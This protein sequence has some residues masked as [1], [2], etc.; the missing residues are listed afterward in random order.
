M[1][2]LAIRCGRPGSE[3]AVSTR[4][5]PSVIYADGSCLR[6]SLPEPFD[7]YGDSSVPTFDP[8]FLPDG[9]LVVSTLGFEQSADDYLSPGQVAMKTDGVG[10]LWLN[11]SG[12]WQQPAWSTSG[13]L[14]A[15]RLV[16]RKAEVFVIDP[17]TGK[18]RR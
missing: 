2:G 13:Q 17:R 9:R 1:P 14:A 6:C 10:V 16:K 3:I 12:S 4:H 8:G 7:L 5:R 18:A 15:V 11:V